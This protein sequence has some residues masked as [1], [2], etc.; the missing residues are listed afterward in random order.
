MNQQFYELI[1]NTIKTGLSNT[2]LQTLI[3]ASQA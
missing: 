1:D 2:A 3:S